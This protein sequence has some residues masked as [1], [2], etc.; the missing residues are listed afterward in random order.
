MTRTL[1]L[2]AFIVF[3]LTARADTTNIFFGTWHRT[4]L[5]F[6]SDNV[7][8]AWTVIVEHDDGSAQF[9]YMVSTD[10]GE[11]LDSDG[12]NAFLV[13]DRRNLAT[14]QCEFETSGVM[15]LKVNKRARTF[16]TTVFYGEGYKLL[17]RGVKISPEALG[18][19][20]NF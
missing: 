9:G 10:S 3:A 1:Y 15:F 14:W 16:S 7:G 20:S 5:S 17:I 4:P 2:L 8:Y 6:D 18:A 19:F 11:V 12:G 13:K